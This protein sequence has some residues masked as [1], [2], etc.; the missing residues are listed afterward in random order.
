MK[1]RLVILAALS[2]LL[3]ASAVAQSEWTKV[4]TFDA[5]FDFVVNGTTLPK[6]TYIVRTYTPGHNLMI[7]NINAARSVLV[8]NNNILL[9]RENRTHETSK[10]VFSP[11]SDGRQ[12]LHSIAITGDDHTHDLIHGSEV[13]EP[14]SSH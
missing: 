4:A 3:A 14:V 7:Q 10:V 6:G 12:V 5:P 9:N 2:L 1:T 8:G 13:I 11:N